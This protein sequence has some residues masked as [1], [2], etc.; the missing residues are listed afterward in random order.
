MADSVVIGITIDVTKP[1]I[2]IEQNHREGI[3]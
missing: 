3:F 2:L 1:G